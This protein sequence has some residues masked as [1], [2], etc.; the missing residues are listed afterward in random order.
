VFIINTFSTCFGHHHA[1]LQE[2]KTCVTARGVLCW[3]CWMWLVAVVGRCVVGCEHC[4][5]Y[6]STRTL[7]RSAPQPLPTTSSRTS[8]CSNTRLVLLKMGIMMAGTCWES[9]DNKHLTVESCW[10]SLSLHN[11]LT[12]H[13][14]RNLKIIC[15]Q[16]KWVTPLIIANFR[17]LWLKYGSVGNEVYMFEYAWHVPVNTLPSAH[18]ETRD[19]SPM[20]C[21]RAPHF[22][23]F[24][25]DVQHARFRA[26]L[27]H[28]SLQGH[29]QLHA[30]C[31][32]LKL[33][34]DRLLLNLTLER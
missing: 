3:F 26:G 27:T 29:R 5:G 34:A 25:H 11:L 10:F 24:L 14:H 9:V 13:G 19:C 31:L 18:A 17:I 8:A 20:R 32:H 7:Q 22:C 2:N 21:W 28:W 30:E 23:V 1:H 15:Y 33:Q 4:E 6:C 16:N 12:M